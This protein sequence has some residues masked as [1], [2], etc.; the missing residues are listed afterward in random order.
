MGRGPGEG[1]HSLIAGT[2]EGGTGLD[3]CTLRACAG[4]AVRAVL[5]PQYGGA[6]VRGRESG[7]ACTQNFRSLIVFFCVGGPRPA[8]LDAIFTHSQ[9]Q[10]SRPRCYCINQIPY[11]MSY[12]TTPLPLPQG[13]AAGTDAQRAVCTSPYFTRPNDIQRASP[14][15]PIPACR[16]PIHM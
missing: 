7:S 1:C 3:G 2:A 12:P 15:G 13:L 14:V 11:G 10:P 16:A 6:R 8:Q 4:K 5:C 9:A